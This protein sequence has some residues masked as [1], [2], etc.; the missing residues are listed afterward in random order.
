MDEVRNNLRLLI[1]N[2]MEECNVF[3]MLEVLSHSAQGG[4]EEKIMAKLTIGMLRKAVAKIRGR[5]LEIPRSYKG[6]MHPLRYLFIQWGVDYLDY[7]VAVEYEQMREQ[8]R[9]EYNGWV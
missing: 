1:F 3:K 9:A 4:E 8:L 6:I 7:P 2:L 5:Q